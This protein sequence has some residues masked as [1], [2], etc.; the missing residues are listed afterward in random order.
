M[1]LALSRRQLLLGGT[2]LAGVAA[3]AGCAGPGAAPQTLQFWHLLS[4]GDGIRMSGLLDKVNS[5]QQQFRIHPTVLAWGAPY[6]TKL[7]GGRICG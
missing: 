5:S 1:T 3:L 2:A 6:Y 4:G 7:L